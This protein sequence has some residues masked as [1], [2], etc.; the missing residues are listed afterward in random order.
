MNNRKAFTLIELL[1]VIAIIALLL[2]VIAPALKRAKYLAMR[3]Q[4]TANV[5]QQSLAFINYANDNDGRYP[6]HMM[7][8][9]YYHRGRTDF[10]TTFDRLNGTYI[11][12]SKIMFCPVTRKIGRFMS[13]L[14]WTE[15]TDWGAWDA[16]YEDTGEPVLHIVSNYSWFAGFTPGTSLEEWDNKI[17]FRNS[18]PP[19]PLTI[20]QANSLNAT[21]AHT[22]FQN[23][24]YGF[25]DYSHGGNDRPWGE[26]KTFEDM[27]AIDNPLCQGDG[28]ITIRKKSDVQ[29]KAEWD[30]GGY[31]QFYY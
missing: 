3:I 1:V 16:V 19:W 17:T 10:R 27:D 22:L 31:N 30:Y 12:E 15:A 24:W 6:E 26:G 2:A 13:S 20:E 18:E 9:P 5:R 23:D 11:E 21:I 4:C 8:L 29:L 7:S 28:S 14:E 25:Y